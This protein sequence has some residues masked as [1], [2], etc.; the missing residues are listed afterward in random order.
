[1]KDY[2]E[3]NVHVFVFQSG[4]TKQLSLL[5]NYW[6]LLSIYIYIYGNQVYATESTCF[7]TKMAACFNDLKDEESSF[8][9]TEKLSARFFA[10]LNNN[11]NSANHD[12]LPWKW[13]VN[14]KQLIHLL[15][16]GLF[17]VYLCKL[18]LESWEIRRKDYKFLFLK[19][20]SE[21]PMWRTGSWEGLPR[22]IAWVSLPCTIKRFEANQVES[23]TVF[24]RIS[25]ALE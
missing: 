19:K 6:A 11:H 4:E 24:T 12:C 14:H 15:S 5:R 10:T 18:C 25:I 21:S 20:V 1:M 2:F 23:M 8:R 13:T 22:I 7:E 17:R 3:E 16:T 9:R